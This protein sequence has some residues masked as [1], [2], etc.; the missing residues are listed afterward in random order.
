MPGL[1]GYHVLGAL[2]EGGY[3][4]YSNSETLEILKKNPELAESYNANKG[5]IS[6][7]NDL[8][9][10]GSTI[11]ISKLP[12]EEIKTNNSIEISKNTELSESKSTDVE[13]LP[14]SY[15][16]SNNIFDKGKKVYDNFNVE[17]AYVK[18][19]HLETSGGNGAKFIG[20]NKPAA[21]IIL[22]DA[23]K[24]G[25][26]VSVIDNGLSS[27]GNKSYQ[28]TIDAGKVIGTRGETFIRIVLSD[29]GGMLSAFPVNK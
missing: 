18:P 26:I 17:N 22:K 20:G 27:G 8:S 6:S 1:F 13:K 7:M 15:H 4:P 12:A 2:N 3:I 10:I 28:L 14:N 5:R 23:M 29:D 25:K 19:K 21:E 24:N 16:S 9:L 11:A